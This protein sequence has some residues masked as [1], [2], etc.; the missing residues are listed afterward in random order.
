MSIT[1]NEDDGRQDDIQGVEYGT[2]D[3]EFSLRAERSGK[4]SGR[5]YT[6]TYLV[7]DYAGNDSIEVVTVDVP[8]DKGKR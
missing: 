6:I 3:T 7:T 1:S 2:E 5:V 4:K 8:H